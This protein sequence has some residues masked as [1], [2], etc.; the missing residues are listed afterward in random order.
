[1]LLKKKKKKNREGERED[2]YCAI[3]FNTKELISD[4]DK[5]SFH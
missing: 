5:S 2:Q 4:L 3:G 1:M